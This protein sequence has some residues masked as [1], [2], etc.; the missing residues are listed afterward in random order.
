MRR[1]IVPN[2][3]ATLDVAVLVL[4]KQKDSSCRPWARCQAARPE[5]VTTMLA[6]TH[7]PSDDVDQLV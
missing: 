5:V 7:R 3:P 2:P 6:S 1:V 4:H